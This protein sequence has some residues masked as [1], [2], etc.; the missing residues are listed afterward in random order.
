M[1]L[2]PLLFLAVLGLSV[3]GAALAVAIEARRFYQGS[4]P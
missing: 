2:E 4:W 3:V 1:R